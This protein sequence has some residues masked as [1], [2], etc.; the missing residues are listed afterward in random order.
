MGGLVAARHLH[1]FGY[2]PKVVYPNMEKVVAK[3]DLYRRLT[4]QLG[5]LGIPITSEWVAPAEGEA[6]VIMDAIFGFSFKGWR[7]EGKDAPFDSIIDYLGSEPGGKPSVSTPVVSVDIP[8][9][10]N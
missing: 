10:W 4:L 9:G 1:H 6:H 8:S 5:Q 7:G 3:N 2:K